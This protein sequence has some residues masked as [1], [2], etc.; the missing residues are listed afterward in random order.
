MNTN[1]FQYWPSNGQLGS[2][3]FTMPTNPEDW[4]SG[5]ALIGNFV[6]S[7]G[8]LV[9]FIDTKAL[10][11]NES[12]TTTIN[13]DYV[14]IELPFAED[15][16]TINRGPRNKYLI[17]KFND[18]EV[19]EGIV[20]VRFEDM[21]EE[22][23]SMF[24]SAYKVI[25]NVLYDINGNVIGEFDTNTIKTATNIPFDDEDFDDE[26]GT[27]DGKPMDALY[28]NYTFK[29][30][31]MGYIISEF[32]SNLSNLTNGENMFKS[33]E[34]NFITFSGDLSNLINGSHMFEYCNNLSFFNGGNL[35]NLIKGNYMFVYCQNLTSFSSDL[36][37]LTDGFYMFDH[38][39]KLTSFNSN[40][41]SL[42]DGG[43]MFLGCKLDT[44]SIQ[45]IAR[46]INTSNGATL[47]IGIGNS[48]PNNQEIEALDEIASKGWCVY[49]NGLYYDPSY[50]SSIMTLDEYGNEV[51]TPIPYYAKPVPS[52]EE[53]ASYIDE[54]GN[55]YNILGGQFIY[56][57]DLS[58]Y[59]MFTCE[60][61][62]AANMRLTKIEKPSV[63]HKILNI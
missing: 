8:E 34:E 19:E 26:T 39:K 48:K 16:M 58:T 36:S 49:V 33:C 31:Y 46:T 56:G 60:E 23:K 59:G 29:E 4:P 13:Y 12:K 50:V 61:D 22:T 53:H 1:K 20:Y 57:D 55:F 14:N 27:V 45:N 63:L 35:S 21:S 7:E 37:N 44:T 54:Q 52:D 18:E 30:G 42:V 6:Y 11:V 2:T 43:Y 28:M 15:A 38:C 24:R 9:D 10:I 25:D 32:S 17:I 5:D 51:S 3:K 47:H 40:L 41:G 62:A